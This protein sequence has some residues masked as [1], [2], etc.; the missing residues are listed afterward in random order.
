MLPYVIV[1][2]KKKRK[3]FS[4]NLSFIQHICISCLSSL[5]MVLAHEDTQMKS[6]SP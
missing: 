6:P 3:E 2:K 5:G 1:K 4:F